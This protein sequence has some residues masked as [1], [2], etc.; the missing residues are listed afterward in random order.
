MGGIVSDKL[1]GIRVT[2][3]NFIL[4]ALFTLLLFST[5]PGHGTGNFIAFSPCLWGCFNRRSWQRL[6]LSDDRGHFRT[7]TRKRVLA[8]GG[9]EAQAQHIAVTETAAALGF[10]SAIGAIGGFLFQSVRHLAGD[11]RLAGRRDEG[12]P[13]VLYR[14]HSGDW[15]VYGRR[16]SKN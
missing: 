2:L 10:I 12:V 15:L 13:G 14:L 5:L 6:D 3:I 16:T 9:T 4:M 1:G 11:D 8:A 7:L